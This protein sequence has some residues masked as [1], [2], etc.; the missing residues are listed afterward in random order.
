M[1]LSKAPTYILIYRHLTQL[2]LGWIEYISGI[3][4]AIHNLP[5]AQTLGSRI[6]AS[7]VIRCSTEAEVQDRGL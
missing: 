5:E 2:H 3:C 1:S 4:Q 7:I 6:I